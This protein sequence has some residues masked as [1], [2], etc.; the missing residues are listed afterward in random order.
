M[1][2]SATNIPIAGTQLS[3]NV[4]YMQNQYATCY[5]FA[6]VLVNLLLESSIPARLR[7]ITLNGTTTEAHTMAEFYDPFVQKWSIADPTFGLLYF[8]KDTGAGLSVEEINSLVL[9]KSYSSIGPQFVTSLKSFWMTTYYVDPITLYVNY[10]GP[11]GNLTSLDDVINNLPTTNDP[12]QTLNEQVL[13]TV[14]S[15]KG[16]YLFLFANPGD[17]AT[18][19]TASGTVTVKPRDNTLWGGALDLRSDS[20][21]TAVSAP[22]GMRIF[23]PVRVLF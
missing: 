22:T 1:A 19:Q 2:N 4:S 15:H 20:T 10:Y 14:V 21:W 23:T 18:L 7:A 8:S 13:R 5:D 16:V 17:S 9:N 12:L 11:G 3:D 6:K